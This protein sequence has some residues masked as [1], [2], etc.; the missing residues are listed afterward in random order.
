MTG[1]L[2]ENPIIIRAN[3]VPRNNP[4]FVP[5]SPDPR[6]YGVLY[7]KLLDIVTD[8]GFEV[9]SEF[10]VGG[11]IETFPLTAPGLGQPWKP[12]SPGFYQ[13]LLASC[14]SIRQRLILQVQ[15]AVDGGYTVQVEVWRELEDL[16][17]PIRATAS[18]V[19]FRGDTTVERGSEVIEAG[20]F[21]S[22]WVPIGRNTQLEQILLDRIAKIRIDEPRPGQ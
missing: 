16:P 17:R 12:G 3:A 22:T 1:P 20:V 9:E 19:A 11:R 4:V 21:D 14:Q 8:F 18:A 6:V 10:R 13:K 5:F 2:Q 15:P 7:E